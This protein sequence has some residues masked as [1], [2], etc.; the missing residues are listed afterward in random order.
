VTRRKGDIK[1]PSEQWANM[2]DAPQWVKRRFGFEGVMLK[3]GQAGIAVGEGKNRVLRV[4]RLQGNGDD[5]RPGRPSHRFPD[6]MQKAQVEARLRAARLRAGSGA[7]PQ[8]VAGIASGIAR[9]D[10]G[11]AGR[12]MVKATQFSRSIPRHK[13]ATEVAKVLN[14]EGHAVT[15]RYVREVLSQSAMQRR[16]GTRKIPRRG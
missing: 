7:K 13:L 12:I 14:A 16:V 11:L 1:P 10:H 2:A 15:A 9:G 6:V 3:N 5:W 4:V 8:R